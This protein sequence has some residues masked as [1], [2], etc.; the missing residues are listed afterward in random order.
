VKSKLIATMMTALFL[1]FAVLTPPLLLSV[2]TVSA[3]TLKVTVWEWFSKLNPIPPRGYPV[4]PGQSAKEV[5]TVGRIEGDILAWSY[6][7][8]TPETGTLGPNLKPEPSATFHWH[9]D[10][11]WVFD[12]GGWVIG[13]YDG[14][15]PPNTDSVT[16]EGRITDASPD[17]RNYIGYKISGKG[18]TIWWPETPPYTPPWGKWGVSTWG[19]AEGTMSISGV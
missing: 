17:K 12:D 2:P 15:W 11:L 13:W 7:W 16:W 4:P 14:V 10:F 5:M 19:Y 3:S 1:T 6:V 9:Q 8:S 18:I